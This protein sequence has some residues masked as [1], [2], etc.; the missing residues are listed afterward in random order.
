MRRFSKRAVVTALVVATA[1]VVAFAV[2]LARSGRVGV[3]GRVFPGAP[4]YRVVDGDTIILDGVGSVRYIGLDAPERDEPY[5]R[6]ARR[7]NAALLARGRIR[8]AYGPERY[9]RFGRTLAYV[10]V[11]NG[12]GRATFVN[13]ELLRAGWAETMEI[14]PNVARAA[15]F[16]G[17]E[18][19][20]RRAG[21]GMWAA[22]AEN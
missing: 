15:L 17:A 1:M 3:W 5:Y 4:N 12:A 20:A 14:P 2:A 18:A 6:Q 11:R 21:R 10:Y 19:E 7:Y 13:E 8:L 22:G 9:D 16:R